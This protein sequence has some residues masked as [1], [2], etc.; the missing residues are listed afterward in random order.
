MIAVIYAEAVCVGE[1][2]VAVADMR[3]R[4]RRRGEHRQHGADDPD[5]DPGGPAPGVRRPHARRPPP[6]HGRLLQPGPRSASRAQRDGN[7]APRHESFRTYPFRI[8]KRILTP[9]ESPTPRRPARSRSLRE[10]DARVPRRRRLGERRASN[11]PLTEGDDVLNARPPY[12]GAGPCACL[13]PPQG[14]HPSTGSGTTGGCPYTP[15][16]R[17][18]VK[19]R[20]SRRGTTPPN[21]A[22]SERPW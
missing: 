4:L 21:A 7:T 13:S 11:P 14:N 3:R 12:V 18:R 15:N 8:A 2:G 20:H 6:D 1:P 10:R 19:S 9:Q 17:L 5:G 22:H 16:D